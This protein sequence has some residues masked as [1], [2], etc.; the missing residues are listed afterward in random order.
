MKMDKKYTISMVYDEEKKGYKME[1]KCEGF[2][3]F[4]LLGI[5]DMARSEIIQQIKGIIV[6]DIIKTKRTVVKESEK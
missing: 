3:P 1:R 4:E 5:L 6:P 2:N